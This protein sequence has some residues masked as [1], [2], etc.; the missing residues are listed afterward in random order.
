MLRSPLDYETRRSHT[1]V[2]RA[3]DGVTGAHADV[4]V[5]LTVLDVND[6]PPRFDREL[7]RAEIYEDAPVGSVLLAAGVTDQDSGPA[8]CDLT[9]DM[10]A[11][12][13]VRGTPAGCELVLTRV[14]DRELTAEH[15]LLLT[16]TDRG[17][18]PLTARA[19]LLVR[20]LDVNDNAP[21]P[22]RAVV[23]AAVSPEA[24]RGLPVARAAAADP[25]GA[26]LEYSLATPDCPF[27]V[28]PHSGLV[29]LE[30]PAAWTAA[31]H[32]LSLDAVASDGA[33]AARVRVELSPAP[34]N[35]HA[36][37][38]ERPLYEASVPENASPPSSLVAVRALDP[39][40]GRYGA[41][42]YSIPS[43]RLR[44]TFS[45]DA[46]TGE[47]SALASLDREERAVWLV[48][49]VAEDGGG[50]RGHGEVRVRVLD[51]NDCAPRFL[52]AE[53]CATAPQDAL[54]AAPLVTVVAT[55]PDE[56][57]AGRVRYSLCS[58]GADESVAIPLVHEHNG[59][60]SAGTAPAG[61]SSW[62]VCATD[63]GGREARV[64]LRLW[65]DVSVPSALQ[66]PPPDYSLP[67]SAHPGTLVARLPPP[68]SPSS[69]RYRVV[70][71]DHPPDMFSVDREGRVTLTGTLD[72]ETAAL[73]HIGNNLFDL[74]SF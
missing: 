45:L 34:A 31:R 23:T 63:G 54:P 40:A 8:R 52:H 55:D 39:D 73:H 37:T 71:G 5:T 38:F 58:S 25:D 64:Q 2:V 67:E 12:F 70:G 42:S 62:W 3:T 9:E 13:E 69:A 44:E 11:L 50:L 65:R 1:L 10:S 18:P 22:E 48:P 7:Y 41:V 4:D 29:T 59:E 68:A 57:E 14:L 26:T 33:R 47:L 36:P 6:C 51:R 74:L 16:A 53:Y 17:D 61:A 66:S 24:P 72:R 27:S 21:R 43:Q 56:G 15:R 46:R 30:D 32:P 28:D 49:V 19:A 35:R 60:V 20:V